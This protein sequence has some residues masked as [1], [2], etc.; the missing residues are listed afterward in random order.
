MFLTCVVLHRLA[1]DVGL[2]WVESASI[3][4]SV[5]ALEDEI[6]TLQIAQGFWKM[7]D[8]VLYLLP[9]IRNKC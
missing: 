8:P 4:S 5:Q 3:L 9:T 7:C 6:E 1:D 2:F